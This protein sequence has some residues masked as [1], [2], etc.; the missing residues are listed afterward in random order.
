MDSGP[1]CESLIKKVV[2][3]LGSGLVGLHM[4][5]NSGDFCLL[6]PGIS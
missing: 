2:R 6:S 1:E 3:S 5:G 4:K